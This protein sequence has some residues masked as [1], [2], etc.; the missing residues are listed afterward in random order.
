MLH[1]TQQAN[2]EDKPGV[3]ANLVEHRLQKSRSRSQKGKKRLRPE[4]VEESSAT[5][6]AKPGEKKNP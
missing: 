3:P 2:K 4:K 6:T 5:L 1:H